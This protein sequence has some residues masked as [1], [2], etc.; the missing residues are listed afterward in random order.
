MPWGLITSPPPSHEEANPTTTTSAP[1][2]PASLQALILFSS[3]GSGLGNIGQGS[4]A[5]ASASLDAAA[6]AARAARGATACSMQW[7]VVEGASMGAA[8]LAAM[9]AARGERGSGSS[10]RPVVAMAGL[11]S[12]PLEAY[13]ACL[14]PILTRISSEEGVA[15]CVQLAHPSAWDVRDLMRDLA[16]ATQAR[17]GELAAQAKDRASMSVAISSSINAAAAA[18]KYQSATDSAGSGSALQLAGVAPAQR[19]THVEAAVLRVVREVAGRCV[20][21]PPD[22]TPLTPPPDPTP[23]T[24]PTPLSSTT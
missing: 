3:V 8:G 22:P 15:W 24:P 11:A 21:P 19:K 4:Y 1:P 17:F 18:A 12:I 5:A 6:I 20:P 10:G 16:D 9:G 2:P 7:P 23:L 14:R 13:A